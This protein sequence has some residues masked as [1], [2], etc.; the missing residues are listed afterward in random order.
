MEDQFV[1]A[2]K[3]FKATWKPAAAEAAPAKKAKP[4]AEVAKR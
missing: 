4:A 1:A 3:E 2:M